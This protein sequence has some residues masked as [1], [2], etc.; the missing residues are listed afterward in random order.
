[1][2]KF[3][4]LV[5]SI[6]KKPLNTL[7]FIDHHL[8]FLFEN[9]D[10]LTLSVQN[11]VLAETLFR[12]W[13]YKT[14]CG[15]ALLG[16][17]KKYVN[18]K[19]IDV[20]WEE[21]KPV[22]FNCQMGLSQE[23]KKIL[24]F[25]KELREQVNKRLDSFITCDG[26][27]PVVVD[28][29]EAAI[30]IP[31]KLKHH[32]FNSTEHLLVSDI[33][34]HK[35]I[36]WTEAL[37]DL[38]DFGISGWEISL[39]IDNHDN[40]LNLTGYS[41]ELPVLMAIERKEGRASFPP[42]DVLLTGSFSSGGK[43]T[44]VSGIKNKTKL[45]S[46][47][48]VKVFFTPPQ[49]EKVDFYP[50]YPI[51]ANFSLPEVKEHIKEELIKQGLDN[52]TWREAEKR[53][54]D[55]EHEVHYGT[56]SLTNSALPRLDK[57]ETVFKEESK[58]EELLKAKALRAVIYCH[59]GRTKEAQV[60][61]QECLKKAHE[62]GKI[63]EYGRFLIQQL[64]NF[65]DL[66]EFDKL[67]K[68]GPGILP[69][70]QQANLSEKKKTDL[71]MRYYGTMGQVYAYA[72]LINKNSEKKK[73]ALEFFYTAVDYAEKHAEEN[74]L[75]HDLN[76]V[77]LWHALF[78]FN[79]NAEQKAY[80]KALT[81][82]KRS[83]EKSRYLGYLYRQKAFGAYRDFLI[84][85]SIYVE[86]L[87]LPAP[88]HAG[89]WTL[90]VSLKY[91]G[92][93]KAAQGNINEAHA[94]FQNACQNLDNQENVLLFLLGMTC[95]VQAWNSLK[96]TEFADFAEECYQKALAFFSDPKILE[97]YIFARDWKEYLVKRGENVENPQLKYPY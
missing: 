87:S 66:G 80:D 73:T 81:Q 8:I 29:S 96:N 95:A 28:H 64:V 30:P 6:N 9:F 88:H 93:L 71:F 23:D 78:D 74:E 27:I 38:S 60:L 57:Y 49:T 89:G 22:R 12:Y 20:F 39:N 14:R 69:M 61:N 10:F 72:S 4:T 34:K 7:L 42:L 3:R 52:L 85:R 25:Q 63:K 50:C 32:N 44:T 70:L 67:V 83:P 26:I 91:T 79:S 31:F 92:T 48:N 76:Y 36:N 82:A 97:T 45:A 40:D 41:L 13:L 53:L 56:L 65:T 37:K 18:P 33:K 75:S 1:M 55:L 54:H 59:T 77:H 62:A 21:T 35:V 2:E 16:Q 15:E 84:N 90:A 58:I 19:D 94:D 17:L 47:L 5:E 11:A 68:M 43:I 86:E 24:P 46:L 51:P